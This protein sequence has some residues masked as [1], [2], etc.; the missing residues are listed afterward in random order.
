MTSFPRKS[1]LLKRLRTLIRVRI[2]ECGCDRMNGYIGT[3]II[4]RAKCRVGETWRIY[5]LNTDRDKRVPLAW[6]SSATPVSLD[7]TTYGYKWNES[8]VTKTGT[9]ITLPEFL[10]L[11]NDAAG[12]ERWAVIDS[13]DVPAETG[14]SQSEFPRRR[15]PDRRPY[16]TPDEPD[17]VWRK[18]GPAVGPFQTKLGDGS[19]VAYSWYRFVD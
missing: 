18:P 13:K 1:I 5:P 11:E 6:N 3:R 9:L 14:L 16:V 8:L 10:R 15:G 12:K 19:V 7:D 17:S 4:G 2:S